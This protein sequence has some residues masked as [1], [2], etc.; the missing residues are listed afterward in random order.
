MILSLYND[1]I[2]IIYTF[3]DLSNL[4]NIGLVSKQL[5]LDVHRKD[6][7]LRRVVDAHFYANRCWFGPIHNWTILKNHYDKDKFIKLYFECLEKVGIHD[8]EI[9]VNT[10]IKVIKSNIVYDHRTFDQTIKFRR[11]EFL[12]LALSR[13][14]N[15]I[16]VL[17]K[18]MYDLWAHA[19]KYKQDMTKSSYH[20]LNFYSLHKS[21]E[22][23]LQYVFEV[24][25]NLRSF[26]IDNLIWLNDATKSS[27]IHDDDDIYHHDDIL[28]NGF[29]IENFISY[30]GTQEFYLLDEI[31]DI[32]DWLLK[33]TKEY[34]YDYLDFRFENLIDLSSDEENRSYD[35]FMVK[36]KQELSKPYDQ[37]YTKKDKLFQ[38]FTSANYMI[39]GEMEKA[40]E[41]RLKRENG[42]FTSEDEDE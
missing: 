32:G 27:K 34:L 13:Q 30:C 3:L 19:Q 39:H 36:L 35:Y 5:Y 4:L 26:I 21:I 7:I 28:S 11:E 8:L 18:Y 10:H 14:Q 29:K 23:F 38:L 12:E 20:Y 33:N 17:I 2:N 9:L 6:Q 40:I 16:K 24:N 37:N 1:V 41:Y 15:I 31:L 22:Y 42:E 25:S